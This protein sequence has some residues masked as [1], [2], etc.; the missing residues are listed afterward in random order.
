MEQSLKMH[1]CPRN[2]EHN[3]LKCAVSKQ[4]TF[5]L[6]DPKMTRQQPKCVLSGCWLVSAPESGHYITIGSICFCIYKYICY[7]CIYVDS[8]LSCTVHRHKEPLAEYNQH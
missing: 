2:S 5:G 4:N 3:H 8:H 1:P 6:S 7:I